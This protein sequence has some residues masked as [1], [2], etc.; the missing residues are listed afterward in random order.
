MTKRAKIKVERETVQV[1]LRL[2]PSEVDVLKSLIARAERLAHLPPGTITAAAYA[3]SAVLDF[4]G[5]ELARIED[6][7][8][9]ETPKGP[10]VWERVAGAHKLLDEKDFT[11]SP[12]KGGKP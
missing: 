5:R 1:A 9:V 8:K 11:Q 6:E 12:K 4:M 3:R 2:A 10:S 7:P